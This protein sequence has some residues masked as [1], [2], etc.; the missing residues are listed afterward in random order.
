MSAFLRFLKIGIIQLDSFGRAG[1]SI[2]NDKY[3]T[4]FWEFPDIEIA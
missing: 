1:S 2:D 3:C 4:D